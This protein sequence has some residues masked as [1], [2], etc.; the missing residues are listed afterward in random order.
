MFLIVRNNAAQ[1][2]LLDAAFIKFF[3]SRSA[4]VSVE[5]CRSWFLFSAG[6]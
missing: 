1:I 6:Q 5:R 4:R 2:D 3:L